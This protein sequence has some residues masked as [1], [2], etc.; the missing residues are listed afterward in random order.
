[1]LIQ[2]ADDSG[3]ALLDGATDYEQVIADTEP[4]LSG[5]QP[6][7]TTC[8]SCTP[9]VPPACPRACC[10]GRTTSSWVPA[11]AGTCTPA[12]RSP[13]SRRSPNALAA[14]E[15]SGVRGAAAD[16]R[17]RPVGRA[18]RQ[19]IRSDAGV[20]RRDPNASTRGDRRDYREGTADGAD[21]RRRRDRPSAA[22]RVREGRT[23]R[24]LDQDL[25]Q[26]R[27]GAVTADQERA[28]AVFDGAI[29]MDGTDRRRPVRR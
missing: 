24:L 15:H 17:R 20:L 27:C 25:R 23:R 2:I 12:R 6:S 10:G 8:T 29:V 13:R 7:P 21:G 4:D 1:M 28:L 14:A 5:A 11:A 3:N 19:H 22:H 16:P 9:A 26:R 18:H